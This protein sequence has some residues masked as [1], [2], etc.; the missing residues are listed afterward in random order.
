[1]LDTMFHATSNDMD[2]HYFAEKYNLSEYEYWVEGKKDVFGRVRS[3]SGFK[4][5]ISDNEEVS[6]HFNDL[7]EFLIVAKKL[8]TELKEKNINMCFNIGMTFNVSKFYSKNFTF[9]N[10]VLKAIANSGIE[11]AISTYIETD[12]ETE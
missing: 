6:E 1:M 10:D 4:F 11:L 5:L 3:N 12:E 9:D 2:V 8:T 7:K